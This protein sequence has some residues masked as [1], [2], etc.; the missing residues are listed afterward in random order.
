MAHFAQID[1]TT[2][3]VTFVAVLNNDQ[4]VDANGNEDEA[5]GAALLEEKFGSKFIQTSYNTIA[6]VHKEEGKEPFRKNYA[7]VG[8][9]FDAE[10]DAFIPPKPY[11]SWTLNEDSCQWNPPVPRPDIEEGGPLILWRWNEDEQQ[12]D[13][14]EIPSE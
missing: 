12:W 5:V 11:P 9:T 14:V 10:R 3:L 6:G 13:K 4:T 1:E 2:N 8:F 7:G